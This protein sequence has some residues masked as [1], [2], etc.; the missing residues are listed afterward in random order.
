MENLFHW[1]EY[2]DYHSQS[3]TGGEMERRPTLMYHSR[4]DRILDGSISGGLS[5]S[6]QFEH[7]KESES[8]KRTKHGCEPPFL[9]FF[10]LSPPF[11]PSRR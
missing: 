4:E 11:P 10:F 7:E 3:D 1:I 8:A 6:S 2:L 9:S 5:R